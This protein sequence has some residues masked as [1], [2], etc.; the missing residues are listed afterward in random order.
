MSFGYGVGLIESWF[1]VGFKEGFGLV[2]VSLGCI[3]GV[4]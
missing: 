4:V 1:G 3:F 2:M